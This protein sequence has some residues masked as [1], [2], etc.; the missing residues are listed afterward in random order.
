MDAQQ[1][2][3]AIELQMTIE[4]NGQI[5]QTTTN[6]TGLLYNRNN[7]NVLTYDEHQ[8]NSDPIKNLVTIQ[9]EKVSIKRTGPVQMHQQFRLN[10][11]SENVFQHPHGNIH[12]ETE[13]EKIDYNPL[14]ATNQG[15][16][17]ITYTVS[18]NGQDARKHQ[19]TMVMKEE[20]AQ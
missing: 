18:L 4:D 1:T 7:M 10:Q 20:E 13:T 11:T 19:L 15:H 9:P 2:R 14:T 6:A 3:V 16:L 5:E 17:A 8:E 12:M